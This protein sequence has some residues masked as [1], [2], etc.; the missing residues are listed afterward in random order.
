[1]C[2]FLWESEKRTV[3]EAIF[4]KVWQH[5]ARQTSSVTYTTSSTGCNPAAAGEI[6]LGF[7]KQCTAQKIQALNTHSFFMTAT[8]CECQSDSNSQPCN[9]LLTFMKTGSSL[10]GSHILFCK[11]HK[12]IQFI[13]V[14]KIYLL[15]TKNQNSKCNTNTWAGFSKNLHSSKTQTQ[16]LNDIHSAKLHH[17]GLSDIWT[18]YNIRGCQRWC[19]IIVHRRQILLMTGASIISTSHCSSTVSCIQLQI[20]TIIRWITAHVLMGKLNTWSNHQCNSCCNILVSNTC[21]VHCAVIVATSA[22]TDTTDWIYCALQL[23][24]HKLHAEA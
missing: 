15:W 3:G 10:S 13:P 23:S 5:T 24:V 14:R 4:K 11:K 19:I 6:G 7:L 2:Q 18:L 20:T 16:L 22:R 8:V 12:K 17:W 9:V 21:H 1:M